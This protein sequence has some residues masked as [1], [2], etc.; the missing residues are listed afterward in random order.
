MTLYLLHCHTAAKYKTSNLPTVRY[1]SVRS[2]VHA[3]PFIQVTSD[4][5]RNT[6]LFAP[7]PYNFTCYLTEQWQVY[8]LL[9]STTFQ[10]TALPTNFWRNLLQKLTVA[11]HFIE[12]KGSLPW[13]QHPASDP[14]HEKD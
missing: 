7:G 13:S 1:I 8:P 2:G 6:L 12:P 3:S 10:T 14:H 11:Q 5:R 4:T 9:I